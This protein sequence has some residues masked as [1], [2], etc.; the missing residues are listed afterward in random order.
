LNIR[1]DSFVCLD[2][3]TTGLDFDYDK[4]I[5]VGAVKYVKGEKTGEF[6]QLLNPGVP[7]PPDIE[8]L[9]GITNQDVESAPIIEEVIPKFESFLEDTQLFV[10]HNVRFDISFIKRHLSARYAITLETFAADTAVLARLV[11]PGLKTFSLAHLAEFLDIKEPPSHRALRDAQVTAELYFREITALAGMPKNIQNLVAGLIFGQQ[12]RGMVLSSLESLAKRFP[13]PASYDYDFGDNVVGQSEIKPVEEYANIHADEINE[14]F[15]GALRQTLPVYEERPQQIEMADQVIGAFNRSEIFL[16]E[17]PTGVGKSLAYLIPAIL[18]AKTNGESVII[19]TGTK[20]LQDQ[21]FGKDI[22]LV[23]KALGFDFKAVLLKGR[24]NYLCLFKYY[25]LLNEAASSFGQEERQAL[26]A[27]AAWAE[28]TKT[29]DV[30]ECTG[31]SPARWRYLWARASCEGNFCLGKICHYYK[32]CF[33]FRVKNEAMTAHVKIINHHLLFADF[34]SGGDFLATSGHAIIDEAHNLEKVAA[35]YL[36]PETNYSQFLT[37]FNQ[38]FTIRPVET[39]FLAL[40]KMRAL[41]MDREE[42][43][44]I[45]NEISK[46]QRKLMSA[47]GDS[48]EFF[49]KLAASVTSGTDDE[50]RAREIS[51]TDITKFVSQQN[52]DKFAQSL[53]DLEFSLTNLAELFDEA[54]SLKD[55][56]ELS[57]RAKALAQDLRDARLAY[58]FLSRADDTDFVYWIEL[59]KKVDARLVS[60]PL[61]VGK[62]LD[63]KFYDQLKT[64]ILCSATLSVAGDF[65]YYKS[66]LGLNL[67]ANDRTFEKA[68]DSPFD[69]KRNIGFYSAGFLPNPNAAN[70]DRE[71]AE[72]IFGL[73]AATGVKGMVLFTAYKNITAVVD[74]VGGRLLEQGFELFVQDGSQSPSRLLNRYKNS[75]KGIIFGTDSFWEGVDLPGEELQLL[76]IVKLPFSVPDKP[77]VKANLDKIEAAGGSPF[78][79]FSLPEAVIKFRQGFGRLIRKKTDSGCVV[80]LDPRLSGKEYGRYFAKSVSP[81]LQVFGNIDDLAKSVKEFLRAITIR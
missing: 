26:M 42:A 73:F 63:A 25:E 69:L 74:S 54:D 31:F 51:Y 35:S 22:P 76:V 60:A 2:L 37:I 50:S 65:T 43:R 46:V 71:A 7:I 28:T 66:R 13:A 34:S 24:A 81:D 80:V 58:E 79:E 30:A 32:R 36:G 20:N 4:I 53:K 5:E 75:P 3:E 57:V 29:G 78:I 19:S 67:K 61:E 14:L 17:A 6:T 45:N 48:N 1:L 68:L 40:A 62:I 70:F 8:I 9:T 16:A 18:W 38:I 52:I 59:D 15:D 39:G 11:W 10:G 77:W 72:V 55:K 49:D 27:L 23:R 33:L 21:L 41:T 56:I 12:S 47:R 64:L 44:R